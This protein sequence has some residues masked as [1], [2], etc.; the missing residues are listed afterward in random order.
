M[1]KIYKEIV[2]NSSLEKVFKYV[3]NP[4][5]WPEF[6]PSLIEVTDVKPLLD[7]GYQA[8]F[9]YKMAGRR[10][11]GE[12]EYTDYTPNHWFVVSTKGGISSKLTFTLRSFNRKPQL[13]QTRVTLTIEYTIPIPLLGKIAEKV[14]HQMNEQEIGLALSNL[15]ARFLLNY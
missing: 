14:V 1:E 3:E 4:G 2:V 9:E 7:G 13:N 15:Q 6:W 5:N 8:K 10:F 11:K 12:G